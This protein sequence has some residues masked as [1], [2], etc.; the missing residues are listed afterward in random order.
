MSNISKK[1]KIN[2][3]LNIGKNLNIKKMLIEEAKLDFQ[4]NM[5]TLII[6]ANSIS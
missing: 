5:K 2:T 6:I 4:I 1:S 3:K